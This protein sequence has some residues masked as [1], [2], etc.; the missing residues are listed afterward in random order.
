MS[1]T[2]PGDPNSNVPP[3]PPGYGAPQNPPAYGTP[4]QAPSPYG[5]QPGYPPQA[6][7]YGPPPAYA[8]APG[9]GGYP[10]A[11]KTNTLAIV[12]L[13]SSI[14]G[15]VI[16]YVIGSVVG[17]ITGHIAL[18]QLKRTN[19]GGRGLALAGLIV[20]Y[21][22]LALTV[23]GILFFVAIF[24]SMAANMDQFPRS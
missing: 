4:P 14:A 8:Q 9:Y 1:D 22:G 20:G 3:P 23:I 10:T 7:A 24:A 21:V 13:I 16:V 11:P 5:Q 15:L 19:E 12:S 6:P 18:A 2:T 17:V